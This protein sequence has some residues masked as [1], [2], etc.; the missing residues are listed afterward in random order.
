MENSRQTIG[1]QMTAQEQSIKKG[2]E[3]VQR[4]IKILGKRDPISI[5]AAIDLNA[6]HPAHT[7]ADT[8]DPAHTRADGKTTNTENNVIKKISSWFGSVFSK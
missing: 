2:D 8:N 7:H 1:H 4:A 6:T 5:Q 3:Y